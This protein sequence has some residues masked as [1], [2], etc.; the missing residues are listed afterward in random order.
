MAVAGRCVVDR[1]LPAESDMA[2]AAPFRIARF[3]ETHSR[4]GYSLGTDPGLSARS[5]QDHALRVPTLGGGA[6]LLLDCSR[7]PA[8]SDAGLDRSEERRVGK[9]CRSR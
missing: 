4:A 3:S 7:G 2:G 9:E 5:G 6:L 1:G 8:L